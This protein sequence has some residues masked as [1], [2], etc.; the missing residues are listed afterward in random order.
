MPVAVLL[1]V[2]LSALIHASWNA[3]LKTTK[4]PEHTVLGIAATSLVTSLVV[5][6]WVHAAV[7]PRTA[8][9][10]SLVSGLL[11]AGYSV[12]LARALTRA[13]F[14]PVYTIVR[15]GAL[16][17]VWPLSVLLF[18]ERITLLRAL[19]TLTVIV[20]LACA[21]FS[22]RKGSTANEPKARGFFMA[23][24]CALFV[25]AYYLSY[26]AALS[27]GGAPEFVVLISSSVSFVSL[28]VIKYGQRR[29]VIDAMRT[30]PVRIVSAGVL[31]TL[32]FLLFL[33]AMAKS[34]AGLVLTLRN[35]SILFAQGIGFVLREPPKRFALVGAVFVTIGAVL[36]ALK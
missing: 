17:V 2:L 14:G 20:G 24:V 36:L 28:L 22:D 26:K 19:G 25:G 13:P 16:V 30:E 33:F 7:P 3:V 12:T 5:A 18:H 10:W 27:S 32:A 29:L 1:L 9:A 4:N 23:A 11:E 8:L 34:G 6:A 31:S 15:G 21:G 35:T